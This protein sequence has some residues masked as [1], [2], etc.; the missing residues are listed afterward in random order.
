MPY[1]TSVERIWEARA[2]ASLLLVQLRKLHGTVPQEVEAKIRKLS[3]NRIGA[4]ALGKAIL[5]LR[6]LQD[7]ESWLDSPGRESTP[8]WMGSTVEPEPGP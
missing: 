7:L 3:K 5:D 8:P 1:V 4:E 2:F 6:S